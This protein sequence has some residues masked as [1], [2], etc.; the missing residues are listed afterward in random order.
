MLKHISASLLPSE[1]QMRYLDYLARELGYCDGR[2]FIK[3]VVPGIDEKSPLAFSR[4]VY[5]S[6]IDWAKERLGRIS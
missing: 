1:K 3:H 5:H 6:A 4:A 2:E